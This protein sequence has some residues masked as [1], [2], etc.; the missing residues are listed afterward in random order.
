LGHSVENIV[1]STQPSV[2]LAGVT[3]RFRDLTDVSHSSAGPPTRAMILTVWQQGRA[4]RMASM[5]PEP[6]EV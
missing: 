3:K 2:R 6:T 5:R 4:D 1:D